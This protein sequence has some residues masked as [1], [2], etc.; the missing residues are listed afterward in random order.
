MDNAVKWVLEITDSNSE[1]EHAKFLYSTGER[2]I[3]SNRTEIRI[4]KMD[5][6]PRGA[7]APE[8]LIP[9]ELPAHIV[10]IAAHRAKAY[11]TRP[12][13]MTEMVDMSRFVTVNPHNMDYNTDSGFTFTIT[14][15]NVEAIRAM[16]E[17]CM[18]S[19][20]PIESRYEP[21]VFSNGS[22]TLVLMQC[23]SKENMR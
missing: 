8:S 17:S 19:Y 13:E 1:S 20:N 9:A 4:L 12:M 3:A 21:L 7:Y 2:I 18:M 5:L 16:G 6:L 23:L 15:S 11:S 22:A 10:S 14:P